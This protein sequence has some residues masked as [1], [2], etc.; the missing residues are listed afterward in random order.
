MDDDIESSSG[1][2]DKLPHNLATFINADAPPLGLSLVNSRFGRG[3]CR[4]C[5]K[6]GVTSAST[7]LCDLCEMVEYMT[8]GRIKHT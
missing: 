2:K 7:A 1:R 4:H 5:H 8:V 6:G 3:V